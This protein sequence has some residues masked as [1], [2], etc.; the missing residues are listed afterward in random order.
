MNIDT[1][2]M[3]FDQQITRYLTTGNI[4]VDVILSML[5][6]SL[7]KNMLPRPEQLSE[8]MNN[9]WSKI[10]GNG[11][12]S[13]YCVEVTQTVMKRDYGGTYS[14]DETKHMIFALMWK[15]NQIKIP[16]KK[17]KLV[18]EDNDDYHS[19][20][21]MYKSM[22]SKLLLYNP[23]E[24]MKLTNG[25]EIEFTYQ[26]ENKDKNIASS[27]TL[28]LYHKDVDVINKFIDETWKEYIEKIYGKERGK[29]SFFSV[30]KNAI[31]KDVKYPVFSRYLFETQKKL[32]DL[33]FPEKD[34]LIKKLNLF[35]DGKLN[36]NKFVILL[37]GPPG[38]GKTSFIKAIANETRRSIINVKLGQIESDAHLVDVFF[39][40]KL[41]TE[42]DNFD[43][44]LKK[45]LYVLE[46]IDAESD[47]VKTREEDISNEQKEETEK[48]KHLFSSYYLNKLYK[49]SDDKDDDN[50]EDDILSED[51]KDKKPDKDK[52][53][54]KKKKWKTYTSFMKGFED[55][56]T[57]SGI[58]NCLD[59]LIELNRGIVIMTT[60]HPEKLDPALIREGR[61]TMKIFLGNITKD[62]TVKLLQHHYP[63]Q[64]L[65]NKLV[66]KLPDRKFTPAKVE[67]LCLGNESANSVIEELINL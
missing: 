27:V 9:L 36:H 15:I 46:D 17:S 63:D 61:V 20:Y 60:N 59:G 13:R 67:N 52:I 4:I 14:L 57:L 28:M 24:N 2:G 19:R 11:K 47:A 38:T 54:D 22:K 37:H 6:L 44:P 8:K 25:I 51:E 55:G 62:D 35:V 5:V 43:I 50:K 58:L 10:F 32:D 66:D 3:V 26:S 39:N 18:L 1:L 49:T 29:L 34:T 21:D 40:N 42:T 41:K 30:N 23:K 53:M 33:F 64:I 45:R 56:I 48:Q 7:L 65:D 12:D 16:S 31:V